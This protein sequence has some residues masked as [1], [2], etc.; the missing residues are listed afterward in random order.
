M[1]APVGAN[2][3]D[4]AI[5][6]SAEVFFSL[7]CLLKENNMSTAVGDEGGFA[8]NFSNN[9]EPIEY[10]LKAIKKSGLNPEKD[11]LI[12]L[13]IASSEFYSRNKYVFKSDN[14]KLDSSQIV[15][16]YKELVTKYPIFSIEDGCS[17]DDWEGW[18]LLN[19]TIGNKT[20]LVGD[21]LFVTNK[22]RLLKGIDKDVANSILIKPNQIGTLS[23]TLD[24]INTAR[25]NKIETIISHRSGE[26][27][28]NFIADLAVGS[29]SKFIKTGSVTRSE[30]C[31]KYNRLLYIEENN[32][33]LVYAGSVLND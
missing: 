15:D 24:T 17:E 5:R 14:I 28:D 9:F 13:D 16:Y 19:K 1:I 12:S 11:V 22:N 3:F 30:R 10:L 6:W 20:L 2:T 4:D 32:N 31:S 33:N 27:E 25:I 21:D 18:T 29:N 8:S 26:T 23:E 7:K